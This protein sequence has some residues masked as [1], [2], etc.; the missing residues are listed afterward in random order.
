M[1]L[2]GYFDESERDDAGQP[3]VVAGYL[4]KP[5]NYK[6]F[7]RRWHRDVLNR[8][9]LRHF[10]AT[11]LCAGRGVYDGMPINQRQTILT[12]AVDAIRA[13]VYAGI[14]VHFDRAEFASLAP[15]D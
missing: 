2:G 6:E 10:H 12:A 8:G 5:A 9:R 3:I 4:F 14:G 11:D 13:N 15:P 7:R 1:V